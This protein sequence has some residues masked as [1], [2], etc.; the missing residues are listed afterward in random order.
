MTALRFVFQISLAVI[1]SF[2][3]AG[4]ASFSTGRKMDTGSIKRIRNN[5]TTKQD[6]QSMFG[7]PQSQSNVSGKES[8]GYSYLGSKA[9]S[10]PLHYIPIIGPFILLATGSKGTSEHQTL[11]LTFTKDLVTKCGFSTTTSKVNGRIIGNST[12][13]SQSAQ[14]DCGGDESPST[15][16]PE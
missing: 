11:T 16:M 6:I 3:A 13:N 15:L 8:W 2:A 9:D 1:V 7:E 12:S 4:C 10:N 5:V 14:I